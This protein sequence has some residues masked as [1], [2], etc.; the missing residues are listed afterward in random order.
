[1]SIFMER[2]GSV[3]VLAPLTATDYK[4]ENAIK[5]REYQILAK[6]AKWKELDKKMPNFREHKNWLKQNGV[7]MAL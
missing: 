1:M 2:D 5:A 6:L 3:R 7:K 4:I